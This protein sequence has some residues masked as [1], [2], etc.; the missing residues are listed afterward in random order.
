MSLTKSSTKIAAY[1]GM[2][3]AL[4]FPLS[5]PA[6]KSPSVPDTWSGILV[7]SACNAD[8]AFAGSPECNKDVP[9]A[10]IALYDDTN[11]V[12]YSL[13]PQQSIKLKL[14]ETVT[15]HGSLDENTI[16]LASINIMTIGL[17]V[18]DKAPAFSLQDQ[19][20]NLQSLD[21]LKGANGTI[22]LFF[23]SADW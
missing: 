6:Q 16:N 19:F 12:M 22:L 9:G 2:I 13:A 5:S 23:R 14:G 3:V 8:E 17:N 1:V 20:G 15:V 10:E 18:G 21:T 4:I 11:R 7:S